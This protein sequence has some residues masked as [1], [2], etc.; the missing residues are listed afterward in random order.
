M[1][2]PISLTILRKG[3]TNI[4]D[5]AEVGVLIPRS[6]TR[7]D[8]AFLQELSAEILNVA[9]PEYDQGA[10]LATVQELQRLGALMFSHLLPEAARRRLRSAQPCALYLRLDEALLQA[11]WEL[12]YDGEQFLAAKFRLGRQ[13]ITSTP[14]PSP[15]AAPRE[16]GP[17]GVLLIAD[18]T[19][20]L[21]QAGEE[22]ERLCALLAGMSGVTV[23][24][25]GGREVRRVP[26]LAAL[27]AHDVVHFAGH[28]YYDAQ[29]PSHSG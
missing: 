22:A 7:V 15:G 25:L 2:S 27:Q 24:L 28:S 13:V 23:T 29:T 14:L 10:G 8:D 3:D 9:T 5:L 18:P 12:A 20:T 11:P 19:E 26:L 16:Q 21:P 17:L 4:V 1:A 6:E